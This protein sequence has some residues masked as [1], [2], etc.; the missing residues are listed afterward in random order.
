MDAVKKAERMLCIGSS[1]IAA[2]AKLIPKWRTP[3]D[4][5]LEKI[6]EAPPQEES[7]RMYFGKVL[8]EVVAQEYVR[9]TG[10]GVH[11]VQETIYHDTLP[12][13]GANV[14]RLINDGQGILEC[15]T[16]DAY[17]KDQ[18]GT[19]GT[20]Q[21][22]EAYLLQVAHQAKVYENRGITYV[23]IAVLIGGNE[24]RIY[25]YIPNKVLEDKI[26]AIA[27]NFWNNHVIPRVPPSPMTSDDLITMYPKEGDSAAIATDEAILILNALKDVRGEMALLSKQ[28]EDYKNQVRSL[29]ASA[30]RLI[31]SDGRRLASWTSQSTTRFDTTTF[32]E[33]HPDLYTTFCK[34]TDSRVL[35]IA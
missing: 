15:K 23:D 14:D 34:T 27:S 16:A 13:L 5:Y 26:T 21:I 10:K 9:R 8:E 24:F 22:P 28:E 6:G 31:D 32:K 25:R 20:D 18:W 11:C 29:I 1:D 19:P 7:E 2:I 33:T 4:V 30:A 12:F 3:L 17:V 35:R